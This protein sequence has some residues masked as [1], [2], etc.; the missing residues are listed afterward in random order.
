[1]ELTIALE[2]MRPQWKE[3]LPVSLSILNQL[4]CYLVFIKWAKLAKLAHFYSEDFWYSCP[5]S[6]D[7]CC[8]DDFPNDK[9]NCGADEHNKKVDE[10]LISLTTNA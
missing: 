6:E 3:G 1:M 4:I 8:N 10:L 5:L 2:T 9:C 7:G